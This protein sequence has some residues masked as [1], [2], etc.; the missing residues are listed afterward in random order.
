MI[1]KSN[2]IYRNLIISIYIFSVLWAKL[3]IPEYDSKNWQVLHNKN[4]WIGWKNKDGIDW[5]RAKATLDTPIAKVRSI[6]EDKKNYPNVFERIEKVK[7]INDEIV[8]I[9]LDMPFPFTSRDY[10]VKYIESHSE[11]EFI[12]SYHS[13]IHSDVPET[14]N[15]IRLVRSTGEWKLSK[16][17]DNQTEVIY[18]WNGELLGDFPDWA[19]DRAWRQQGVEVFSWLNRAL[20]K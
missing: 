5:C 10:I 8:Y 9:A 3:I 4:T 19:L 11:K 6:I 15:Y 18:T 20:K 1:T 2:L 7:I 17:G 16:I 13:V 12:Y 14:K